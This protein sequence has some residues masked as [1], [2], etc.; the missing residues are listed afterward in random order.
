VLIELVESLVSSHPPAAGGLNLAKIPYSALVQM[1]ANSQPEPEQSTRFSFSLSPPAA[2]ASISHIDIDAA[3]CHPHLVTMNNTHRYAGDGDTIG[4]AASTDN[5]NDH[6][7]MTDEHFNAN[8]TDPDASASANNIDGIIDGTTPADED[9]AVTAETMQAV[10][11]ERQQI[12]KENAARL[13]SILEN[14]K[15]ATKII[16]REIDIYLQETEEVEKTFIRCRANTRKECQRMEQVEPDVIA[17]TQRETFQLTSFSSVLCKYTVEAQ[18]L[19]PPASATIQFFPQVSWHRDRSSSGE[20][21][22]Q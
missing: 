19:N 11:K 22:D 20:W 14:I 3:R 18:L 1:I 17:A 8:A 21:A 6:H 16:L 13:Q 10:T 15:H 9:D 4:M 2:A 12:H 5:S 7:L